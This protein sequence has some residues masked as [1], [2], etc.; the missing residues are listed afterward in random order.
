MVEWNVVRLTKAMFNMFNWEAT[1]V[2]CT[3]A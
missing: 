2:I 3:P 1:F